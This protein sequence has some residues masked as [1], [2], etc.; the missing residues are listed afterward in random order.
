[1][2]KNY[3]E[4][5]D[6]EY[7]R[8]RDLYYMAREH[9]QHE[10]E[11]I[12]QRTTWTLTSQGFLILAYSAVIG[13]SG[14]SL[15]TGKTII[16]VAIAFLGMFLSFTGFWGIYSAIKALED[17]HKYA[18]DRCDNDRKN[19][20]IALGFPAITGAGAFKLNRILGANVLIQAV[21]IVCFLVWVCLLIA[22]INYL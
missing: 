14:G 22:A 2:S 9:V 18:S 8:Q 20:G 17:I 1:M 3:L 19:R 10:D 11:L 7:N 16:C 5:D 15:L 13:L 4:V 12:N 21:P 6:K